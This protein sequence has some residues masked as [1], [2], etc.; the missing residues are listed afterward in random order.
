MS[1]RFPAVFIHGTFS[2]GWHCRHWAERFTAAG[3]TCLTPSLP[4]HDPT[5]V[6]ALRRLTLGDYLGALKRTLS[7]LPQPPVLIGHSM[8][9]LLAQQLAASAPCAALICLAAVPPGPVLPQPGSIVGAAGMVLPMLAGIPFRPSFRAFRMATAD[10]LAGEQ[11]EIW[12]SLGY[13]SPRAYRAM[14]LG[15]R[16]TSVGRVECPS[17][18]MSGAEDRLI[19]ERLSAALAERLSARHVSVPRRGHWLIARTGVEPLTTLAL[20]WLEGVLPAPSGP[21]TEPV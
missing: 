12:E 2:R 17:L 8:G 9:G 4:G 21:R 13:E 11:R 7:S 5:D 20:E 16:A 6:Q 18:V 10:L 3:Y 14:I 15:T 19:S 1:A